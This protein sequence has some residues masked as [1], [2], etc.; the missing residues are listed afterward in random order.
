[1]SWPAC[2]KRYGCPRSRLTSLMVNHSDELDVFASGAALRGKR[3]RGFK[4]F[5][6][7][8][9]WSKVC[10]LRLLFTVQTSLKFILHAGRLGIS[11][12]C[13]NSQGQT[14]TLAKTSMNS[15]NYWCFLLAVQVSCGIGRHRY[16]IS[17]TSKCMYSMQLDHI[18]RD[19]NV[20]PNAMIILRSRSSN[21]WECSAVLLYYCYY[22]RWRCQ[23]V[24]C[25]NFRKALQALMAKFNWILEQSNIKPT[26]GANA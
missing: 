13:H 2:R 3:S 4:M 8:A 26:H 7:M 10:T 17:Y 12:T 21:A 23:L 20:A 9:E 14:E 1:M 22:Y 18:R 6:P 19:W 11:S 24:W 25:I 5:W 16:V 15:M